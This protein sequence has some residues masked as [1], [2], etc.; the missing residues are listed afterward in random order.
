MAISTTKSST[1]VDFGIRRQQTHTAL[2]SGGPAGPFRRL[3]RVPKTKRQ[4][5]VS[6]SKS[7]HLTATRRRRKWTGKLCFAGHA[8]L[9]VT[10]CVGAHRH[11][12]RWYTELSSAALK[13]VKDANTEYQ[14][15][16]NDPY[17]IP[18]KR[19]VIVEHQKRR[20]AIYPSLNFKPRSCQRHHI[21]DWT[22]LVVIARI[23]REAQPSM[24][25][26]VLQLLSRRDSADPIR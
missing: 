4:G 22:S 19:T 3:S 11:K 2:V 9:L 24:L 25:H 1:G 21:V 18:K 23:E 15:G 13:P 12:Q 7:H 20:T 26:Q 17:Q 6:D 16:A 10:R 5:A 14:V 8:P